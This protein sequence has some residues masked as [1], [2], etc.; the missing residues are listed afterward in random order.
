M[1]DVCKF[2]F[3]TKCS[4]SIKMF[5]TY[6]EYHWCKHGTFEEIGAKLKYYMSIQACACIHSGCAIE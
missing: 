4:L 3:L 2:C 5:D 1:F 6:I